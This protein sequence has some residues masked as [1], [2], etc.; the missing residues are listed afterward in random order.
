MWRLDK[1]NQIPFPQSGQLD[2]ELL[3]YAPA[4]ESLLLLKQ[5]LFEQILYMQSL[6]NSSKLESK[7]VFKQYEKLLNDQLLPVDFFSSYQKSLT[8]LQ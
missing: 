6:V 2:F 1:N 5:K 4:M 7:D 8:L 3:E